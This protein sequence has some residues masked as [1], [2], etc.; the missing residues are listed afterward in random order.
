MKEVAIVGVGIHPWGKH[1]GKTLVD[2]GVVAVK[3]G[4]KDANMG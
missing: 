3:N 2:L 4:L 1:D